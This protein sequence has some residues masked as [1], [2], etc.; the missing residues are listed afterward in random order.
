MP[1]FPHILD[2]HGIQL[3]EKCLHCIGGEVKIPIKHFYY[4]VLTPD[5]RTTPSHSLCL[6]LS[7]IPTEPSPGHPAN[8]L[9]CSRNLATQQ[10]QCLSRVQKC[11]MKSPWSGAPT[12]RL[13][14][15]VT[16]W[17]QGSD[18]SNQL[19]CFSLF[20][21]TDQLRCYF[22]TCHTDW[23]ASK[24][25]ELISHSSGGK[26]LRLGCQCGQIMVRTLFPVVGCPLLLCVWNRVSFN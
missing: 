6:P 16:T 20:Q 8:L 7:G 23:V 2:V 4:L 24:Q 5:G 1:G 25:Q 13:P 18:K 21:V 14:E 26:N 15:W 12:A 10:Q 3:G 19:P 17:S 9:P 11:L 22:K